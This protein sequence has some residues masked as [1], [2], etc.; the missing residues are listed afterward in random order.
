MN[1]LKGG[2]N[3]KMNENNPNNGLEFLDIITIMGFFAQL[4][5]L[6]KDEKYEQ[7]IKKIILGLVQE[8]EKLHRENDEII[9]KLDEVLERLK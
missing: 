9:K 4:K 5:N 7:F 8:I 6:S 3:Q 1:Y 2:K